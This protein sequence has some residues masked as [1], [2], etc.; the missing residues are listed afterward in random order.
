ML[1]LAAIIEA[2]K[3]AE[4]MEA[5]PGEPAIAAFSEASWLIS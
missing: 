1:P 2:D 5:P 4:A 3:P